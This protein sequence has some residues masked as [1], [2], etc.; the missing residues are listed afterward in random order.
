MLLEAGVVFLPGSAMGPG[1]EGFARAS[2]TLDPDAWPE[3]AEA[4]RARL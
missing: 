4:V 3:L 1:G 2:L